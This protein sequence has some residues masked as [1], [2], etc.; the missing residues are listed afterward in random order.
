MKKANTEKL[1]AVFNILFTENEKKHNCF[2]SQV[3]ISDELNR[4]IDKLFSYEDEPN[5]TTYADK[6]KI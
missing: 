3:K 6:I 4:E 2:K 1:E 5:I